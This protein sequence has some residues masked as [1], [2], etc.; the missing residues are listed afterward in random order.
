MPHRPRILLVED[1]EGNRDML[2]WRLERAGFEIGVAFDGRAGLTAVRT[3]APDLIL[4]DLSLPGINGWRLAKLLKADVATRNI[5]V[6]ALTAHAMPWDRD[7]ALEAGC[8]DYE[9]KPV[10]FARLLGKIQASLGRPPD[11]SLH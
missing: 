6:I 3:Q 2:A 7:R 4:L 1:D 10:E 5:P 8:D 11:G 9:T